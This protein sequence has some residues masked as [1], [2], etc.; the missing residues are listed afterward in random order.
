[1]PVLNLLAYPRDQWPGRLLDVMLDPA[2]REGGVLFD[3]M[4]ASA[5]LFKKRGHYGSGVR[6]HLSLH[7]GQLWSGRVE[8]GHFAGQVLMLTLAKAEAGEKRPSV[9]AALSDLQPA[10]EKRLGW[11]KGAGITKLDAAWQHFRPTAHLWAAREALIV[12]D[13]YDPLLFLEWI[14]VA[15]ELRHR[16]EALRPPNA[17]SPVLDP[18]KTWKMPDELELPAVPLELPS[19]DTII[20]KIESPAFPLTD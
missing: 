8:R 12:C 19:V 3:V 13:G 6:N 14:I 17:G 1:M 11:G 7:K 15:E 9:N 20:S 18:D 10:L 16:G 5:L 4:E 2:G